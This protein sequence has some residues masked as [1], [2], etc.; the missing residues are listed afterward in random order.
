MKLK[1]KGGS[2]SRP[3]GKREDGWGRQNE[4]VTCRP[5]RLH[6]DHIWAY[7]RASLRPRIYPESPIFGGRNRMTSRMGGIGRTRNEA[8][9]GLSIEIPSNPNL[10]S[11]NLNRTS[12][13]SRRIGN[14][15]IKS[16]LI[17][18]QD[19]SLNRPKA[20]GKAWGKA[21]RWEDK[22]TT[23]RASPITYDLRSFLASLRPRIP[24]FPLI[25][26]YSDLIAFISDR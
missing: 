4:R 1:W 17:A 15:I 10:I 11:S 19:G 21:V 8:I 6:K 20:K 24:I 22:A 3:K 23:S 18:R 9:E 5:L 12:V 26:F 16:Y 7:A 14:D 2:L 13:E 25:G